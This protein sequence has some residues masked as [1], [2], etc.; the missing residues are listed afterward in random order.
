MNKA[1]LERK[2]GA[3]ALARAVKQPERSQTVQPNVRRATVKEMDARAAGQRSYE[4]AN[5][6][7]KP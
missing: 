3:E 4:C 5:A 1:R 6:G 7:F 2:V